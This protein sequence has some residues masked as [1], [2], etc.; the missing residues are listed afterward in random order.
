MVVVGENQVPRMNILEDLGQVLED[1][2][3]LVHQCHH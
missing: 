3:T 2:L 1:R